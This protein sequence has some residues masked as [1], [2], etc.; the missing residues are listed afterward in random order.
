MLDLVVIKAHKSNVNSN[1]ELSAVS[2]TITYLLSPFK[3]IF[4]FELIFCFGITV[5]QSVFRGWGTCI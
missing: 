5:V 4:Y 3:L 2:L 1:V